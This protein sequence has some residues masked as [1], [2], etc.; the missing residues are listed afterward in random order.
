MASSA[1]QNRYRPI[2]HNVSLDEVRA[3]ETCAKN[4]AKFESLSG[5]RDV[6]GDRHTVQTYGDTQTRLSQFFAH[7]TIHDRSD[8]THDMQL[9]KQ[10]NRQR[11]RSSSQSRANDYT[12]VL[13]LTFPACYVT[14]MSRTLSRGTSSIG[15]IDSPLSS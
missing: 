10:R 6:L 3:T 4:L 5:V 12:C 9:E 1:P 2:V 15:S 14:M 8:Y 13:V 11:I 7:P